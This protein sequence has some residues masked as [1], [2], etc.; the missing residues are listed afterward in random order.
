MGR[1]GWLSHRP[2][3]SH[4]A[5][6]LAGVCVVG[7]GHR[8]MVMVASPNSTLQSK[9]SQRGHTRPGDSVR[10]AVPRCGGRVWHKCSSWWP[11]QAMAVCPGTQR[12]RGRED[13]L[14]GGAGWAGGQATLLQCHFLCTEASVHKG[15]PSTK[16]QQIQ[17]IWSA[18][19]GFLH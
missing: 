5:P 16:C 6:S 12:A 2:P 9:A 17:P 14:E 4:L 13:R 7:G 19:H 1:G 3:S 15:G 10:P 11:C 18:F 8:K